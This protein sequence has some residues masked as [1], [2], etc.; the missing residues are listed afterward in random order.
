M[1]LVHHGF[2][3]KIVQKL[4]MLHGVDLWDLWFVGS[5]CYVVKEKPWTVQELSSDCI[6]SISWY[7]LHISDYITSYIHHITIPYHPTRSH[8]IPQETWGALKI[9]KVLCQLHLPSEQGTSLRNRSTAL[10][11]QWAM[12][13]GPGKRCRAVQRCFQTLGTFWDY[14]WPVTCVTWNFLIGLHWLILDILDLLICS[15][16]F[17]LNKWR[18]SWKYIPCSG[19]CFC[20]ILLDLR[21]RDQEANSILS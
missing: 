10:Q 7:I 3:V 6:Y 2:L 11:I 5:S 15:S 16:V 8:K 9:L 13:R 17:W 12:P 20:S 14:W 18:R 19:L 21:Y 4:C 1:K